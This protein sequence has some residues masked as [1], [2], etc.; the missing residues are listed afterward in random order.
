MLNFKKYN[1]LLFVGDPH[2]WSSAPGKRLD[3][4]TFTSTILYKIE[5]A[6]DIAIKENLYLIFL[7]DLFHVSD[8]C[9]ID[10]LTK[11][12]RIL[13]KLPEPCATVEGNHE[14]SQLKLSDDVAL[15]LFRE[16]GVINTIE[17][18]ALWA[19]FSFNDGT[20]AYIGATPHG[21]KLPTEVNLP[22][23]ENDTNIPII[24]LSHHD[25]DF[26]DT[27]P[28]AVPIKE[29]KGVNMLVNG[30]IHKTK[31]PMRYG[32][33]M[34]HNPGNITRLSTDCKDHVPSV[35]KWTASQGFDLEPIDLIF[36]KNIFNLV[37]KQI[38][39]QIVDPVTIV[40][41]VTPQQTSRFVEKMQ[42]FHEE[43]EP[44]KTNDGVYLKE[45]IKALAKALQLDDEFTNDIIAIADE[46][47]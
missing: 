46:S 30:H 32:K 20:E 27:Y 18:S 4:K 13:R 45:N 38:E 42:Q 23:R 47:I 29:I 12:M 39:V 28:G 15:S 43:H 34:A 17:K 19:K 44:S 10:M 25:L 37:G 41:E 3:Q 9:N 26:G 1:G 31:K 36:E 2:L 33:M 35:W 16:S 40:E 21:E 22:S 14:K 7:G 24:W 6:V 8:E 11:L 5:Q